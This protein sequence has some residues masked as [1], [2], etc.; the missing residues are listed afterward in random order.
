MATNGVSK[1]V[2]ATNILAR[3]AFASVVPS[4]SPTFV[5]D[6]P[7]KLFD[8]P[9][10]SPHGTVVTLPDTLLMRCTWPP[11]H[12]RRHERVLREGPSVATAL[13]TKPPLTR[14]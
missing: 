6:P 11:L 2:S 1:C 14:R 9:W 10:L 5:D 3:P 8:A 4:A 13:H 12:G 7:Q